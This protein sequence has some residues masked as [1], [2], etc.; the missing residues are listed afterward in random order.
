MSDLDN[1]FVEALVIV[2][3]VCGLDEWHCYNFQCDDCGKWT[4]EWHRVGDMCI[5]DECYKGVVRVK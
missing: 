2:C 4:H 5:C 3:S 1:P